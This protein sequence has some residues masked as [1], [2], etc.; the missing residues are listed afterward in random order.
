MT[1]L[2]GAPTG[3][4]VAAVLGRQTD[5]T[6][7]NGLGQVVADLAL[8]AASAYTRGKGFETDGQVPASLRFAIL[9]RAVRL[10]Q[11]YSQL[12]SESRDG[13][14]LSYGMAAAQGWT[15]HEVLALEQFRRTTA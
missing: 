15:V 7:V 5:A 8:E 12:V 11:N 1:A 6:F 14:S 10:A 9:L 3:S 4:D 2:V 13:V